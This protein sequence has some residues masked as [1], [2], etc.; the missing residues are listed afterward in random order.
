MYVKKYEIIKLKKISS[1]LEYNNFE[2]LTFCNRKLINL[3][4][5][6]PI[7]NIEN[8][9]KK[10]VIFSITIIFWFCF[11]LLKFQFLKFAITLLHLELIF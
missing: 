10:Y 4:K 7:T 5:D 3:S 2:S 9:N 8:I 11:F 6:L 1:P